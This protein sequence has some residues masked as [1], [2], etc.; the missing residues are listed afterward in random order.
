MNYFSK[1]SSER[2]DKKNHFKHIFN[3]DKFT[4][5]EFEGYTI[6]NNAVSLILDKYKIIKENYTV[7]KNIQE[8]LDDFKD[9]IGEEPLINK[10]KFSKKINVDW[11]VM[12][13]KEEDKNERLFSYVMINLTKII[14]N[15]YRPL[16]E[17][18]HFLLWKKNSTLKSFSDLLSRYRSY[19]MTSN[20]IQ[21]DLPLFDTVLREDY[22]PWPGNLDGLLFYKS[23]PLYLVEFQKTKDDVKDHDNNNYIFV[24]EEKFVR[25]GNSYI[26]NEQGQKV[27]KKSDNYRWLVL[28]NFSESTNIN[29]LTVVWKENCKQV[30]LKKIN[31]IDLTRHGNEGE[32]KI[33]WGNYLQTT[34]ENKTEI[35]NFLLNS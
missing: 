19:V 10:F 5:Y 15:G 2:S 23:K 21:Q 31:K 29:I 27:K 14:E 1:E 22:T 7:K 33:I 9:Y 28:K 6:K 24:G 25:Q 11:H 32:K 12:F 35:Q 4:I 20:F 3:Q 34:E 13:Y 17:K 18:K 26:Y 8:F 16:K 30:V